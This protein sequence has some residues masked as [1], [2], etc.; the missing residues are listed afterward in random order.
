M[1]NA[2]SRSINFN[3]FPSSGLLSIM[4]LIIRYNINIVI[5]LCFSLWIQL[6]SFNLISVILLSFSSNNLKWTL[7]HTDDEF[8]QSNS[9][10]SLLLL[11]WHYSSNLLVPAVVCKIRHKFTRSRRI[12]SIPFTF[13]NSFYCYTFQLF[14]ISPSLFNI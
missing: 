6:Y 14:L 4:L 13:K 8:S 5:I 12:P 11:L 1:S 10:F 3:Y 2:T 7:K 9:P